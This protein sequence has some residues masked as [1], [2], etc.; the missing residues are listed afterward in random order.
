M[1]ARFSPCLGA[2]VVLA[3]LTLAGCSSHN[4]E[5][6]SVDDTPPPVEPNPTPPVTVENS[7]PLK[8]ADIMRALSEKSFTYV[9][10]T[11]S[12]TISYYGDGTFNYN[13]KGKGEGSGVWQ[14]SDGKLCQALNP[15]SFLPK[16]TRSE[17]QPFS[18]QDGGYTAGSMRLTPT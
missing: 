15:T 2:A 17:C 13:E 10:A 16:G 4:N 1:P 14:A 7:G 3:V 9:A 11:R 12:G 5:R 18:V 8:A 6:V